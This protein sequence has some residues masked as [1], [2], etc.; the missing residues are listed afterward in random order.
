M[1]ARKSSVTAD[2]ATA[3]VIYVY[4]KILFNRNNLGLFFEIIG[5]N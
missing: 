5:E 2:G 1:N 3:S 4:V